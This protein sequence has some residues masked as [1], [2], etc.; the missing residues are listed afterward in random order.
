MTW[1]SVSIEQGP[2]MSAK[3]APP[4]FLPRTSMTVSWGWNS[5]LTSLYGLRMATTR[6]TPAHASSGS[7]VSSSRS[8]IAPITATRSPIET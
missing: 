8:P 2:A 4:I 7:P 1:S 5:R 3:C 6:S